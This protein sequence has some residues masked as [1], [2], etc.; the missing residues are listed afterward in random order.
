MTKPEVKS[1]T[2]AKSGQL[3]GSLKPILSDQQHRLHAKHGH[4]ADLID[5]LRTYIKIK[6]SIEKDYAQAL[7]KLNSTHQK[8]YPQFKI[9]IESEDGT[10]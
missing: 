3:V 9:E 4:D 2:A 8:K 6:C 10:K 7:I 5:D 1:L